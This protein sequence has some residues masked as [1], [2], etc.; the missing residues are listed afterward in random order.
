MLAPLR[1][2]DYEDMHGNLNAF[3]GSHPELSVIEGDYIQVQEGAQKIIVGMVARAKLRVATVAA[4][5][6]P[7]LKSFVAVT[8]MAQTRLMKAPSINSSYEMLKRIH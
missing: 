1:W 4:S 6:H 8:P 7:S 3:L 5:S 2:S